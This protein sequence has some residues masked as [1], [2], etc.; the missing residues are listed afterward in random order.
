MT[1]LLNN[2]EIAGINLSATTVALTSTVNHPKNRL[3][4]HWLVDENSNRYCQWIVETELAQKSI[5]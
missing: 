5:L 2:V 4:A 3:V 1:T